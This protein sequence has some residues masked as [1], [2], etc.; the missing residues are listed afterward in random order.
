[1]MEFAVVQFVHTTGQKRATALR[2]CMWGGTWQRHMELT[3]CWTC[4]G[5]YRLCHERKASQILT[6]TF[7]VTRRKDPLR[8]VSGQSGETQDITP[9]SYTL[10][11]L[12]VFNISRR[13]RVEN[14]KRGSQKY[15]CQGEGVQR[16][17]GR[18]VGG[19]IAVLL[20]C[21]L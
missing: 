17:R 8:Q 13:E 20:P 11:H 3:F 18:E 21:R 4:L 14:G 12:H 15:S 5:P 7:Q 2:T 1:M 10:S 9:S 16:Y 6:L 19:S